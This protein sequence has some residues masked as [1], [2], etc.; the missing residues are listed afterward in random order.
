MFNFELLNVRRKM[1]FTFVFCTLYFVF[2]YIWGCI[3]I[4]FCICIQFYASK[5]V[6]N[7]RLEVIS[8]NLSTLTPK[9]SSLKIRPAASSEDSDQPEEQIK[10]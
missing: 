6:R 9:A 4:V 1:Y 5:E 2:V 7:I 3:C 10:N 8:A